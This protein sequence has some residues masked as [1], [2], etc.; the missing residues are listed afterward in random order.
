MDVLQL[1]KLEHDDL[2][3]LA[4]QLSSSTTAAARRTLA[5]SLKQYVA[6]H[7]FIESEY[8]YPEISG[9]F[10]GS[11]G[12]IKTSS[13]VHRSLK[14]L[15]A[16]LSALADRKPVVAKADF[17]EKMNKALILLEKHL[18]DEET[19][20]MPKLREMISTQ[21]R[22]ELGKVFLDAIVPLNLHAGLSLA[23]H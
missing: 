6:R 22:E 13:A 8:L 12:F 17:D 7:L 15:V 11:D 20:L 4:R 1:I 14:K 19:L 5:E 16:E 9:T 18:S 2:R 3:T 21:E 10:H 23:I